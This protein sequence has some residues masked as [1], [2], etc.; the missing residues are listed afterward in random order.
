MM[1]E[2]SYN[3]SVRIRKGQPIR[4]LIHTFSGPW[5]K[6]ETGKEGFFQ[7]IDCT[8]D[9]TPVEFS[10]RPSPEDAGF[11]PES[12]TFTWTP[13][14]IHTGETKI[15]E[16][17][18][19]S[20]DATYPFKILITI[21]EVRVAP[22][23]EQHAQALTRFLMDKRIA[24]PL[25][26]GIYNHLGEGRSAFLSLIEDE[27]KK[28]NQNLDR[29]HPRQSKRFHVV[30]FDASEYDDQEKIW[31]ALLKLLFGKYKEEHGSRAKI[32]Y[33]QHILMKIGRE[34]KITLLLALLL[35]VLIL[36]SIRFVINLPVTI[37][38]NTDVTGT[39]LA[40]ILLGLTPLVYAF[41]SFVAIPAFRRTSTLFIKP[42]YDELKTKIKYPDYRDRLG[43]RVEVIESLNTLVDVW[44]KET[45]DKIVV[46]V[47]HIDNCSEES[48]AG[49]FEALELFNT[50]ADYKQINFIIPMNPAPVRLALAAKNLHRLEV[51]Q[52]GIR[53]KIALGQEI[54][55]SCVTFPY[56]LPPITDYASLIKEWLPAFDSHWTRRD[57]M[58]IGEDAF[59]YDEQDKLVLSELINTIT[60][61]FRP[62][63]SM[64][65]KKIVE[66]LLLAKEKWK[67]HKEMEQ[68]EHVDLLEFRH[69]FISWFFLEYFFRDHAEHLITYLKLHKEELANGSFMDL[70]RI[71]YPIQ[72][73]DERFDLKTLFVFLKDVPLNPKGQQYLLLSHQISKSIIPRNTGE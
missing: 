38:P 22:R 64:E 58:D 63:K 55:E 12:R 51:E 27:I 59:L 37:A 28:A 61:S 39:V 71:S 54:L 15:F 11:E 47:D 6:W 53:D 5:L 24:S 57:I 67:M 41:I 1:N 45:A 19:I 10:M 7:L 17:N 26:I 43:T 36:L 21:E 68:H 50:N 42:T 20:G 48:I 29:I 13:R 4:R 49:F 46:M 16:F 40:S 9:G 66:F 70:V 2:S 32:A 23:R 25:I 35:S 3:C 18:A 8:V 34:R 73:L 60:V 62:V 33:W 56:T 69:E 44:L 14:Q 31:L 30:R 72:P 52:P 65:V